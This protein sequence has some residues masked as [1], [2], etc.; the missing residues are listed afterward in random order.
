MLCADLDDADLFILV[1]QVLRG[2][3]LN[4]MDNKIFD[5][6][7]NFI[8]FSSKFENVPVKSWTQEKNVLGQKFQK[9]EKEEN[10]F[11]AIT[12]SK[13]VRN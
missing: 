11:F 9:V 7:L 3:L 5:F 8:P 13:L 10:R 1:S 6:F 4:A 12:S 2:H